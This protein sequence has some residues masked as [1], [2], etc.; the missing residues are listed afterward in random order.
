ME[1]P[2]NEECLP[3]WREYKS[4]LGKLHLL[5]LRALSVPASSAAVERVFS[6]GGMIMWP[7]RSSMSDKQLSNFVFF[8]AIVNLTLVFLD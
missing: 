4:S 5:A 3:F 2:D 7:H 6:R 1:K 8:A